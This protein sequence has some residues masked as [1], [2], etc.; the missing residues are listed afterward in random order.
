MKSL[1]SKAPYKGGATCR[2]LR[3]RHS[4]NPQRRPDGLAGVAG[5]PR[6]QIAVTSP[7]VRLI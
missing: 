6:A 2:G 7:L 1:T 3:L 4:S 5:L